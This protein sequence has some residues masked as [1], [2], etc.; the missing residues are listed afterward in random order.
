MNIAAAYAMAQQALVNCQD[1]GNVKWQGR[2]LERMEQ[3]TKALP[4]GSGLNGKVEFIGSASEDKLTISAEYQH[5]DESGYYT[6]WSTYIITVRA[7]FYGLNVTVKGRKDNDLR[8]YLGEL[9][10]NAL[11]AEAPPYPCE[12]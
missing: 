4:H 10:H 1:S 8:E 12:V 7:T 2:W 5:M 3:L 11:S 9:F 6:G